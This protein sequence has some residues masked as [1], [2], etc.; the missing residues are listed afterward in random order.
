MAP[1]KT[2][3]IWGQV[4]LARKTAGDVWQ[5]VNRQLAERPASSSAPRLSVWD[6]LYSVP[7]GVWRQMGDETILP[8]DDV[9]GLWSEAFDETIILAGDMGNLWSEIGDETIILSG[10]GG[11]ELWREVGDE[12]IILA[13]PTQNVWDEARGSRDFT[14]M[15][16]QRQLGYALKGFTTHKGEVYYVLKNLRQGKYLRLDERQYFL[17]NL[18]DGENTLQ[19]IAVAYMSE[20]DVLDINSLITL[21]NQLEN[22]G[23]LTTKKTSVYDQLR[24]NILG[25]GLGH[26]LKAIGKGFL[27]KE[28]PIRGMDKFYTRTY[29]YGIKYFYTKPVQ[30]LFLIIAVVGLAAFGILVAG[31]KYSLLEGGT[32]SLT[33]G[34]VALYIARTIALFIHEGGHAYTCKHYGREIHKSGVMIYYGSLAFYVDSTDIWLESR[35]PRIMVSWGGPYTGFI[36]GGAASIFALV[37]PW[38]VPN[39]L[40]YQFAFLLILDSIFN[41]NPLLKWD[42]Y[43]ILMDIL[44]MPS[45]RKRSLDFLKSGKLF[46]KIIKREKFSREERVFAIYGLLTAAYTFSVLSSIIIF[47]GKTIVEYITQNIGWHWIGVALGVLVL[48][49]FRRQITGFP[50]LVQRWRMAKARRAA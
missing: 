31:G 5:Q 39:G 26:W 12:T 1:L 19:D 41:L 46:H 48:Y 3:G 7:G 49:R 21:L 30:I 17:W 6:T 22:G 20:Y 45:L 9:E 18:M 32:S 44:E 40:A 47:F 2:R 42:G 50:R 27:Q 28:F 43:Y 11:P 13:T 35:I 34:V 15:Q 25:R 38:T 24:T 4:G 37:S 33:I 36:L 16:P 10:E 14:D 23:F 29:N 8:T